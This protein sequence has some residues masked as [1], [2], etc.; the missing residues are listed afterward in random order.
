M[1]SFW[2]LIIARVK[3]EVPVSQAQA[4]VSLMF[5]NEMVRASDKPIFKGEYDP[6]IRLTPAASSMGGSQKDTLHPLYVMMLCV[7][8]VL[9]IAC[10]NVAGLL[11]ARSTRGS[12]GRSLYDW[13]WEPSRGGI[14]RQL[15]DRERFAFRN[16]RRAG[17]GDS[18]LGSAGA[19][20]HV[21]SEEL[22]PDA[23]GSPP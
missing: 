13:L 10:A 19:A 11:L 1:D 8:V 2:L 23:T 5:R 18:G 14:I 21:V 4:A 20:C 7:G 12:N 9:L 16:R 3:P 15:L 6:G 17:T 22:S